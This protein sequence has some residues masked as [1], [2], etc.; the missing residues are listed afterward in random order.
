MDALG[1]TGRFAPV[2]DAAVAGKRPI[3]S[4]WFWMVWA[5]YNGTCS[6]RRPDAGF[7]YAPAR[8]AGVRH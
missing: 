1:P 7:I 8:N 5:E 2:L 4:D 3:W 6:K